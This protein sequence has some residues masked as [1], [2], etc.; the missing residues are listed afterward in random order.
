MA[1]PA[2]DVGYL[3]ASYALPEA[4]IQSLLSEPTVELVQSLLTQIEAKAREYDEL[5]S[6]KLRADIENETAVRA[7]EARIRTLQVTA[8]NAVKEAEEL[9]QQLAQKETAHQQLET[10]LQT[11]Q[12]TTTNSSSQ[13]EILEARVKTLESQN[14][15]TISLHEAKSAAYDRLAEELSAQ[16]QKLVALRKQVSE[17]EDKKQELEAAAKDVTFRENNLRQEIDQLRTNNEWYEGELKTRSADNTRFRKEKNA[18][19]AELQRASADSTQTIESLRSKEISQT[20]RIDE[21]EQRIEQSLTRIQEL[22]EEATQNQQ[23]FRAE[24]DNSR[25]LAE[26][27][28]NSANT[29]KKRLQEVQEQLTI[30]GDRA[31][32]E[33]GRLQ[34]EVDSERSSA[35]QYEA[36]VAE[37]EL[38]VENQESQ[39][40]ELRN[41]AHIPATPRRTMNGGFSTPGRAGSPM[42]FSPGGSRQK[43]GLTVTQLYAENVKLKADIRSMDEK[44]QAQ[45]DQMQEMLDTLENWQPEIEELRQEKDRLTS[46]FSDMSSLLQEALAEK[47]AARKETRKVQGEFQ[48]IER[49][50]E[51]DQQIIRDI[52][53]Q[54]KLLLY[55]QKRQEEGLESLSPEEQQFLEDTKDNTIPDH[56]LDENE[57]ATS[58]LLSKHMALF[59]NISEVVDRNVQLLEMNRYVAEQLEGSEA[60]AKAVALERLQEELSGL[61]EKVAQYEDEIGS[62]KLRCEAYMKER[63]MYRRLAQS[64]GHAGSD[65]ASML[66]GTPPLGHS[67]SSVQPNTQSKEAVENSSVF[68]ELQKSLD[69]LREESTI[70][71]T[72]LTRQIDD[73]TKEIRQ[74][75]HENV[76]LTS[77][78][79]MAQ[80]WHDQQQHR[81]TAL[82]SQK[83]LLQKR[84]DSAQD[85]LATSDL[86]FQQVMEE[87]VECR[88]QIENLE[89]TNTNLKASQSLWDTTRSRLDSEIKAL[90]EAKNFLSR[91]LDEKR[92]DYNEQT[93]MQAENRRLLESRTSSLEAELTNAQRKLHDEIEEHKRVTIR[94]ELDQADKQRKID[95][96]IKAANEVR[97]ELAS[98]RTAR[99]QLQVRVNELQTDLRLAEERS[100]QA[101]RTNGTT[102]VDDEG[103]SREEQLDNQLAELQRDYERAKEKLETADTHIET[104][105]NIAQEKEEQLESF[106]EAHD[107]ME[108]D[109]TRT[110]QQ[111]EAEIVDLKKR[112][113]EFSS[114]LAT[115]G[116]ELSELRNIQ[117]KEKLELT[118][119]KDA[120]E[121]DIARIQNDINEYAAAME[122]QNQL[123]A[124]QAEIAKRAQADYENELAKHGETMKTLRALRDQHN[125]LSTDVTEYRTQAEAARVTLAQNEE[126]WNSIKER[127]ERE[128]RETREEKDG[129]NG[130]NKTLYE[131]IDVLNKT[132]KSL[133]DNRLSVAG[134]QTDVI[135]LD[136]SLSGLQELNKSLRNDKDILQLKVNGME[137]E[138]Q[139]VRQELTTKQE[140]LER[141]NEKLLAEQSQAQSRPSDAKFKALEESV[142]Q[143]NLYRESNTTLRNDIQRLETERNQKDKELDDL[144]SQLQPLQTRVTELEGELEVNSGHLKAVEEDRERW[145]KR[146]QDVLQRYDRIDPKELEDL[147]QQ[148][149]TLQ[150]ER[151]QAVEQANGAEGRIRI[152][153]EGMKTMEGRKNDVRDKARVQVRELRT[154][155]DEARTSLA[156]V[157]SELAKVQEELQAARKDRDEAQAKADASADVVMEEEG[158]VNEHNPGVAEEKKQLEARLSE[159]EDRERQQSNQSVNLGIQLE[160]LKTRERALESQIA[161]LQ[162]RIGVLSKE[163]DEA[164]IE[165]ARANAQVAELQAQQLPAQPPV[166]VQPS[167]EVEKLKEELA[168]REKEVEDLRT[169]ADMADS[170]V[171][172]S[173]E[174]GAKAG[175]ETSSDQLNAEKAALE[176]RRAAIEEREASLAQAEAE[177]EQR[178][179]DIETAGPSDIKDE[180][181]A[182]A[183]P[184]EDRIAA[185]EKKLEKFRAKANDALR[186]KKEENEALQKT[187]EE[188]DAEI[189]RLEKEV[190]RLRTEL[191]Q[192]KQAGSGST[193]PGPGASDL[194]IKNF[195]SAS[196]VA[197]EIV[198]RNVQTQVEAIRNASET[199]STFNADQERIIAQRLEEAA[200]NARQASSAEQAKL[201]NQKVKEATANVRL[202]QSRILDQKIEEVKASEKNQA[203]KKFAAKESML[204]NKSNNLKAKW[205]V[206]VEAAQKTP[207]KTVKEVYDVA[208]VAKPPPPPAKTETSAQTPTRPPVENVQP[209]Q[210]QIPAGTA[211][212]A[213][214]PLGATSVASIPEASGQQQPPASAGGIPQ[215]NGPKPSPFGQLPASNHSSSGNPFQQALNQGTTFQTQPQNQNHFGFSGGNFQAGFGAPQQQQPQQQAPFLNQNNSRPNSPFNQQQ[216][217]Q[218]F[219]GRGHGDFGTGPGALQN[220]VR[221]Q[222][223]IPRGAGSSI[224]IPGSRGRGGPQQQQQQQQLQNPNAA[225]HGAGQSGIGRGTGRGRG[226]G[227]GQQPGSPMNP[228]AQA[229]QPGGAKGQKRGAEDEGTGAQRGKRPRGGRG[230]GGAGGGEAAAE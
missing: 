117:E 57:T 229:F 98:V 25:R 208:S 187:I 168:A 155:R 11:L 72:T 64:H 86:K 124:S 85:Q 112:V 154:E 139:R 55:E 68:K 216:P 13:V 17:L 43:G 159:A 189:V 93:L 101:P 170:F 184:I 99:D 176:E 73:L 45:R 141:A 71:R 10:Q 49:Q 78:Q 91:S 226:G 197:K 14:R 52:T 210:A 21:L 180:N 105:K 147:K 104:Y 102:D 34:A 37:L 94:Y 115:T 179:A 42:T 135:N 157:Q 186:K 84:L 89:R 53:F 149:E 4:S 185:N 215:A 33:I 145:Q 144:R 192:L 220:I 31:A 205:D 29:V 163:V 122:T 148:I 221:G 169:Q 2:V 129:L 7:G 196:A 214:Q 206:V 162:Q 181:A 173:D 92:N 152:A 32:E 217:T 5:Q 172:G 41:T 38:V 8:D 66:E 70:D 96:L 46:E 82:E 209:V 199:G 140:Q 123:V 83:D 153:E 177:L 137:L 194:E 18:Q 171:G 151:D 109:T 222:S 165:K 103:L 51:L 59:R 20:K 62:L 132:I 188:K 50:K 219:G 111:K 69:I 202:E 128:L 127:Q 113:E 225:A 1:A 30:D 47:E 19:L 79:E 207:E 23:S 110:I 26:L 146:H 175:P 39:L 76:R 195:I 22:Q 158:Q 61:K 12:T 200:A 174:T 6:E 212:P 121:A 58:Q 65:A 9:R 74:L 143:L 228:G 24:L 118:Q 108:Q 81:I 116:T 35:A 201:V 48:G 75:Q 193:L 134:G 60:Q 107:Q 114:E 77:K 106:M 120:L 130:Q 223:S 95:D 164:Q 230:G 203:E 126:H 125:K 54:N 138:V 191:E 97:Q 204:K 119:Q 56:L 40:S 3:A 36:K 131:Q 67:V 160:A 80:Q 178:K 100:Q 142:S 190:E 227:R 87:N 183:S 161:E 44:Y 15:D 167:E 211:Q 16:H 63:D 213:S 27:H 88:G 133:Q 198:R 28:Q 150:S 136:S 166:N 224:P 156:N 182:A 218:S 90:T